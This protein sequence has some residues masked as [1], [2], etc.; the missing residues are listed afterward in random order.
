MSYFKNVERKELIVKISDDFERVCLSNGV[1][2]YIHN[3]LHQQIIPQI[4][5]KFI[6]HV[7]YDQKDFYLVTT[8][9]YDRDIDILHTNNGDFTASI[10]RSSTPGVFK[11]FDSIITEENNRRY[12]KFLTCLDDKLYLDTIDIEKGM[13]KGDDTEGFA[14]SCVEQYYTAFGF[15]WPYFAYAT[16]R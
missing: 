7:K 9:D 12:L 14:G 8:K 6:R 3:S 15:N 1:E 16:R 13:D 5:D 2:H 11:V 10:T 4:K